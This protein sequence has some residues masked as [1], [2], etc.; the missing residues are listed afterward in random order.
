MEWGPVQM[1]EAGGRKQAEQDCKLWFFTKYFHYVG[2][3]AEV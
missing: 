1:D 3:K 2:L